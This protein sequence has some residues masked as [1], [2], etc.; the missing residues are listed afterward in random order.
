MCH[1][2]SF[3]TRPDTDHPSDTAEWTER[4]L[5]AP[6]VIEN[7]SKYYL[8][9]YI[10]ESR[11]CVGVSD[12]PEGPF[13]L[14]S[15]YKY[16]KADEIDSGI[17]NDAG[18]L[19]DDDGKVYIFYGFTESFSNEINP[20]NMYEIVE[21]STKFHVIDDREDVPEEQRFFEASSPRKNQWQILFDLF[22]TQG[23]PTC[24]CDF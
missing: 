9:A 1:G 22:S 14:L 12:N 13:K 10:V 17:Y 16:N 23:Q 2:H 3:H 20:D 5:Y 4:E 18:V 8:Y 21:G 11:G 15:R 24:L 6:D 19:V 7:D